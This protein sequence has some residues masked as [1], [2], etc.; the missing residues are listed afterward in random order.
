MF[1]NV[2]ISFFFDFKIVL[3]FFKIRKIKREI[4]AIRTTTKF[5]IFF[6][7]DVNECLTRTFREFQLI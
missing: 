3:H 4:V 1:L 6:S 5:V 2:Q 7:N